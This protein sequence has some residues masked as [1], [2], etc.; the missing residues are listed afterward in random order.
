MLNVKEVLVTDVGDIEV[1]VSGDTS[2]VLDTPESTTWLSP[3]EARWVAKRLI[4][5]ADR[6]ENA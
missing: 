4:E 6:V 3:E 5:E 2:I 1:R